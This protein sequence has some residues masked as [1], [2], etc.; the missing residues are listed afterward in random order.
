MAGRKCASCDG[1]AGDGQSHG[2]D[3]RLVMSG[4]VLVPPEDRS[5]SPHSAGPGTGTGTGE[6]MAGPD[7]QPPWNDYDGGRKP[8]D[9]TE[10]CEQDLTI[11]DE[12]A[13]AIV[14]QASKKLAPAVPDPERV[15]RDGVISGVV[16]VIM[17]GGSLRR[18]LQSAR[19]SVS[20]DLVASAVSTLPMIA[21]LIKK[22]QIMKLLSEVAK[23]G[24]E[25]AI[26][27]AALSL[28]VQFALIQCRRKSKR[29]ARMR[30]EIDCF[31]QSHH[32]PMEPVEEWED[33]PA[34]FDPYE[35]RDTRVFISPPP[36][37]P[38]PSYNHRLRQY[39]ERTTKK[40]IGRFLRSAESYDVKLEGLSIVLVVRVTS[41]YI[42]RCKQLSDAVISLR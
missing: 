34:E 36:P 22:K 3:S 21:H 24:G 13:K 14:A 11:P 23:Q 31:A 30:A 16:G 38:P 33:P 6:S 8:C 19:V 25:A 2:E 20:A 29:G 39:L 1:A 9:G 40:C 18:G 10:T 5:L 7:P 32:E 28:A 42:G 35:N 37:P 17:S 41:R 4:G 27:A 26:Q 12:L 15:L